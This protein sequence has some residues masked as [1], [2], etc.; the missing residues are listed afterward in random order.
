MITIDDCV[1]CDNIDIRPTDLPLGTELADYLG[2]E[3][4]LLSMEDSG[5]TKASSNLCSNNHWLDDIMEEDTPK[6]EIAY[7]SSDGSSNHGGYDSA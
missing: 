2:K 7:S 4:P 3:K 5:Q 1:S 6:G